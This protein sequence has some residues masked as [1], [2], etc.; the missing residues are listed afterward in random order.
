MVW[1]LLIE[2]QSGEPSQGEVHSQLLDQLALT[3]DA[4]KVA[5]Q[6]DSQQHLRVDRGSARFAVGVAK[7]LVDEVE[8]DM[9]IDKSQQMVLWGLSSR[10]K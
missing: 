10:R 8:T 4:V 7:N 5:N 6:Q 9:A 3:G 1:N 2:A